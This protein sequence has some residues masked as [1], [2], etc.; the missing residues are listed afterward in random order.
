MGIILFLFFSWPFHHWLRARALHSVH[1]LARAFLLTPSLPIAL[2]AK[3]KNEKLVEEACR[4]VRWRA[5]KCSGQL[6]RTHINPSRDLGQQTIVK[7]FFLR[8]A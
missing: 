6:S 2:F 8:L 1:A 5:H 4:E 3:E 7:Y